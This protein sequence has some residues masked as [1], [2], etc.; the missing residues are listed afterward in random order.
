M[1]AEREERV[2]AGDP[3]YMCLHRTSDGQREQVHPGV[4]SL[5]LVEPHLHTSIHDISARTESLVFLTISW[6]S[7]LMS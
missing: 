6:V 5:Q 2:Q 4:L 3:L 7:F 1:E